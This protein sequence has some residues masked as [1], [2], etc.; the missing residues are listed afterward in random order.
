MQAKVI[1]YSGGGADP[2]TPELLAIQ[3]SAEK[4]I[5]FVAAAGNN[6]TNTDVEKYYPANYG[7]GNIISVAATNDQGEWM[8]F[9]NYGNKIDIA[10]PGDAIYS[11]LPHKNYGFMSG[12]SQSTAFISGLAASLLAQKIVPPKKLINELKGLGTF[13]EQ[14]KGKTKSQL[15]IIA[16]GTT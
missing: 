6:R 13:S 15:A 5:L 8:P 2:F 1:N 9:S 7:L 4:N 11:T 3:K 10:A 16:R 12:T 14:L